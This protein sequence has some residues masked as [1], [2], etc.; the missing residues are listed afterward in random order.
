VHEGYKRAIVG[1]KKHVWWSVGRSL[2]VE[3]WIKRKSIL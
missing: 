1:K 3:K 2:G